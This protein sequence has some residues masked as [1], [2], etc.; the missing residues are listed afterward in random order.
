MH[1]SPQKQIG[2]RRDRNTVY[3]AF[4]LADD[5]DRRVYRAEPPKAR[6]SERQDERP[7]AERSPRQQPRG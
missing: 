7:R 4:E 2:I 3:S 6:K 5:D 1:Q